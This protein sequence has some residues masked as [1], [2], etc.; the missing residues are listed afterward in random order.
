MIRRK[1]TP[2]IHPAAR[3]GSKAGRPLAGLLLALLLAAPALQSDA[4]PREPATWDIEGWVR[5][6]GKDGAPAEEA[7]RKLADSGAKGARVMSS[8]VAGQPLPVRRKVVALLRGL[9]AP[10]VPATLAKLALRDADKPLRKEAAKGLKGRL[11]KESLG[12]LMTAAFADTPQERHDAAKAIHDTGDQLAVGSLMRETWRRV[13]R[14]Q[15]TQALIG[16]SFSFTTQHI[17]NMRTMNLRTES[18]DANGRP[19]TIDSTIEL[20]TVERATIQTHIVVPAIMTLQE[21]TG[22]DFGEDFTEWSEWWAGNRDSFF[23]P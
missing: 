22:Q 16:I 3:G 19:S 15:A 13:T 18:R 12:V 23:R 11:E 9:D 1:P 4:P 10:G 8:M 14:T 6:L 7:R 21:V 5:Q 2:C 20:P 17:T